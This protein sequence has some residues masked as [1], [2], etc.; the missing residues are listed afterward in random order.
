MRRPV[1]LRHRNLFVFGALRRNW[2]TETFGNLVG[3]AQLPCRILSGK[4]Y[5]RMS[6]NSRSLIN[7]TLWRFWYILVALRLPE[8]FIMLH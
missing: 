8:L 5:R 4:F 3:R 2:M 6:I 7:F 1:P